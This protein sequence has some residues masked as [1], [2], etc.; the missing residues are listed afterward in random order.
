M[1]ALRTAN[2]ILDFFTNHP[3]VR[4]IRR[5]GQ[6]KVHRVENGRLAGCMATYNLAELRVWA[7]RW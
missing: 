6:Y 5:F 1:A 2:Q 7:A 3:D 4:V